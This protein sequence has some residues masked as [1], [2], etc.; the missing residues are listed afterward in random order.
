MTV[1][2]SSGGL[3]GTVE[4]RSGFPTGELLGS[5]TVPNIGGWEKLVSPTTE[6]KDPGSTTK[7]YAV[8]SNPEWSSDKADLLSVD[9]L[10]FSGPGVEKETKPTGPEGPTGTH[11]YDRKGAYTA[12]LTVTDDKGDTT[13]GA[14]RIDVG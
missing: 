8:F 10:H 11:T 9:W 3:G 7:L 1:G 14:V 4:F 6:L 13:T 5:V 2:A 12:H